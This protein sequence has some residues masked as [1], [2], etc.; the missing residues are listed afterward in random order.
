[1]RLSNPKMHQIQFPSWWD[2][3]HF[4][5]SKHPPALGPLSL[6]LSIPTL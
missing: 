5:F 2:G 3:A 1:M 6:A 4:P